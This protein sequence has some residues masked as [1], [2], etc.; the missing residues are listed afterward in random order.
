MRFSSSRAD[1]KRRFRSSV[2]AQ[3]VVTPP[4]IQQIGIPQHEHAG[5]D[6]ADPA[7]ERR[8]VR[9]EAAQGGGCGR[10]ARIPADD[11]RVEMLVAKRDGVQRGPHRGRDR[12]AMLGQ[13]RDVVE[14]AIGFQ[15]REFEHRKRRQAHDRKS[16]RHDEADL[17]HARLHDPKRGLYDIPA[18]LRG[19]YLKPA[20]WCR[21][22]EETD[23]MS[24]QTRS[25]LITGATRRHGPRSRAGGGWTRPHGPG[26]GPSRGCTIRGAL[27]IRRRDRAW[28]PAGDRHHP[29]R[30]AGDRGRLSRLARPARPDP[31]HRQLRAGGEGGRRGGDRQSVATVCQPAFQ[32]QFMPRQLPCGGGA[33]LVGRAGH[34]SP[35]HLFPGMAALPVAVALFEAGRAAHARGRRAA[36]ADRRRRPGPRDRRPA[37]RCRR[38]MSAPPSTCP[39]RSR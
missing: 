2:N 20:K 17:D 9:D 12:A 32:K 27:P 11:Q 34:P 6:R 18:P 22:F 33:E 29:C 35:P 25:V 23:A 1:G 28:G 15:V 38:T 16:R 36:L 5:A 24:S 3:C 26:H 13:H 37:E 8:G 31:G 7:R 30:H 21:I 39:A 10:D 19:C 14:R 4:P